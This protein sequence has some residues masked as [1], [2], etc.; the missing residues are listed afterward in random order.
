M[1][2]GTMTPKLT[3]KGLQ[4]A[5]EALG[6]DY[7]TSDFKKWD[8]GDL[9]ALPDLGV[10]GTKFWGFKDLTLGLEDATLRKEFTLLPPPHEYAA[11]LKPASKKEATVH[12]STIAHVA[13][14][15]VLFLHLDMW[16]E[17]SLKLSDEKVKRAIR[18]LLC[19]TMDAVREGAGAR[20]EEI[21]IR[22]EYGDAI[23]NRVAVEARREQDPQ[24]SKKWNTVLGKVLTKQHELALVKGKPTAS[25]QGASHE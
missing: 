1:A 2:E 14:A 13:Y 20:L 7:S 4:A 6:A 15:W 3:A 5:I 17:D 19:M 8:T 23:A 21:K 18:W 11:K 25:S 22:A 16:T 24:L 10:F 9:Y 12:R